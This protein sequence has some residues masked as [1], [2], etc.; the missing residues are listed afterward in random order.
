[1]KSLNNYILEKLVLRKG[2]KS[3]NQFYKYETNESDKT[4]N[5]QQ[6]KRVFGTL[7]EIQDVLNFEPQ[8]SNAPMNNRNPHIIFLG[9]YYDNGKEHPFAVMDDGMNTVG[10]IKD[11]DADVYW[12]IYSYEKEVSQYVYD[13][14]LK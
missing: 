8:E 9:A 7:K 11:G 2:M 1:M 3:D 6:F 14:L 4:K 12:L 10:S 5:M 13:T